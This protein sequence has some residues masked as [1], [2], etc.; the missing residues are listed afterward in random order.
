[1]LRRSFFKL[2]AGVVLFPWERIRASVWPCVASQP[3]W[4]ISRAVFPS[5]WRCEARLRKN[6]DK[7]LTVDWIRMN[8]PHGSKTTH[9]LCW[10]SKQVTW[11]E[12]DNID[13]AST[14]FD[15]FSPVRIVS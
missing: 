15:D 10:D 4:E 13:G 1:M 3:E 11:P 2:V 9:A 5:G 7:S 6:A 12:V 8:G 14:I